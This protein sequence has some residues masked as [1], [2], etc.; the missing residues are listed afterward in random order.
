MDNI[1]EYINY[2]KI[3]GFIDKVRSTESGSYFGRIIQ[4]DILKNNEQIQHFYEFYVEANKANIIK[5]LFQK[6]LILIEGNLTI[7]KFKLSHKLVVNVKTLTV[8][9]KKI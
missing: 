7:F 3:S 6:S 5:L 4:K 1:T 9:K 2:V 8:L